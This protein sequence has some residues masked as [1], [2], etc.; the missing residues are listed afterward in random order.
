MDQALQ[1]FV[2][3]VGNDVSAAALP[4]DC[5]R[6]VAWCIEKL[7]GLY[8]GFHQTSESRYIEEISR[9]VR[10]VLKELAT[11]KKAGPGVHKLAASI[12]DRL[13]LLHEQFGLPRLNLKSLTA[14]PPR[15]RKVS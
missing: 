5:K 2:A 12:T 7:P 1:A 15:S 9:F 4:K 11:N 14:P 3:A 13:R 8:A 6:T 10:A